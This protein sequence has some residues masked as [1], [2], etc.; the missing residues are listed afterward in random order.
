MRVFFSD[1]TP[2]QPWWAFAPLIF[3]LYFR[4]YSLPSWFPP[5]PH[6][7]QTGSPEWRALVVA[8]TKQLLTSHFPISGAH[9]TDYQYCQSEHLPC[10]QCRRPT[11]IWPG[12]LRWCKDPALPGDGTG[13]QQEEKAL[14]QGKKSSEGA[15][16]RHR[17]CRSRFLWWGH[18]RKSHQVS[19]L[20]KKKKRSWG[21][22]RQ[23]WRTGRKRDGARWWIKQKNMHS[24]LKWMPFKL[25]LHND[26]SFLMI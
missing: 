22:F 26:V 2:S 16:E 9:Y 17:Y 25:N 8:F 4:L 12:G 13:W 10:F 23:R 3:P 15:G 7:L 24:T 11:L 6:L 14:Q 20:K 1:Y 5:A 18:S 19:Y 21:G